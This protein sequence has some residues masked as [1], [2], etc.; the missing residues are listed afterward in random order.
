M[1]LP[2][3]QRMEDASESLYWPRIKHQVTDAQPWHT[4]A[5]MCRTRD[6]KYIRRLYEHDELYD[7]RNDPLEMR[8]LVDD[9]AYAEVLAQL[10][11]RMLTWYLE[12][13]D[14][15]PFEPDRRA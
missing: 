9:P 8:N 12:T 3:V 13:A 14:V 6:H 5:V 2:S 15:V 11:E 1:E 7:L 4:K 10:K